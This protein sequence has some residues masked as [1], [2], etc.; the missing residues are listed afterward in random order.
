MNQDKHFRV[1][2]ESDGTPQGTR[3]I[4]PATGKELDGVTAVAFELRAKQRPV[5]T[6][7]IV[8]FDYEA[9]AS[10]EVAEV[11][12]TVVTIPHEVKA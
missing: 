4:D 11:R 2:V 6:L 8:N 12:T 7:E 5:L 9:E 3:V 10:S 1:K